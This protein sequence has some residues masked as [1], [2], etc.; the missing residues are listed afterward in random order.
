[1]RILKQRFKILT[2]KV[3]VSTIFIFYYLFLFISILFSI[4][5]LKCY[6]YNQKFSN[7]NP[8][9]ILECFQ[10]MLLVGS[11]GYELRWSL[12][13]GCFLGVPLGLALVEL[14]VKKPE[15]AEGKNQAGPWAR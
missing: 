1:M 6:V 2:H 15:R 13:L 7:K 9:Q 11:L 4:S 5:I 10:C 8:S 14:R 12:V 3:F